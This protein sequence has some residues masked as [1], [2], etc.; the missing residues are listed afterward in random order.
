MRATVG[1]LGGQVAQNARSMKQSRGQAANGL[2]ALLGDMDDKI[3]R[4]LAR[5]GGRNGSL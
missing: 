2:A 5:N 3:D 4:V 1:E